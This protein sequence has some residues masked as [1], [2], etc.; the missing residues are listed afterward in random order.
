VRSVAT[1]STDLNAAW[2]SVALRAEVRSV[3]A[4]RIGTGQISSTYRLT[5][6]AD[7]LPSTPGA[8]TTTGS[9]SFRVP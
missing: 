9:V 4:E 6:D 7:G 2:L 3:T 1:G 5:I 8:S